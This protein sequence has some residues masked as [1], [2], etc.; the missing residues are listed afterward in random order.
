MGTGE[1]IEQKWKQTYQ[2]TEYQIAGLPVLASGD[3][4]EARTKGAEVA[5]YSPMENSQ[6]QLKV[7]AC[8]SKPPWR[9]GDLRCELV[10]VG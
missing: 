7:F 6:G 4:A 1:E 8:V 2:K 10:S 3:R 9:G 5:C